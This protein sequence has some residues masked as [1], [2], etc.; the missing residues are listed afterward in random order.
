[1]IKKLTICQKDLPVLA[2]AIGVL[3]ERTNTRRPTGRPCVFG[4]HALPDAVEARGRRH[5]IT[6]YAAAKQK[7]VINYPSHDRSSYQGLRI[8]LSDVYVRSM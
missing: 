4:K 3:R 2:H 7:I 6:S 8:R 1:M 5:G